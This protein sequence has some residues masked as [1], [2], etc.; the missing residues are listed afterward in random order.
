MFGGLLF[1]FGFIIYLMVAFTPLKVYLIPGYA[2]VEYRMDARMARIKAD[3][4]AKSLKQKE[5]YWA[6]VKNILTG[7][8][9][10]TNHDTTHPKANHVLITEE[11]MQLD[12]SMRNKAS[13]GDRFSLKGGVKSTMGEKNFISPVTGKIVS[14]FDLV[15]GH[16]GVD[17]GT[18]E[19]TPVKSIGDGTVVFSSYTTDG[20]HEI[21]VQ[22]AQDMIS[23][24]R[25]N[26]YLLK[27]K[28]DR[29]IGGQSIAV[30]GNIVETQIGPHLHFELWKS[31]TPVSPINYIQF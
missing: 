31:G 20:G 22:H 12:E 18:N 30:V 5:F 17:I 7:G 15:R 4:L 27:K 28:G 6:S 14:A 13:Q 23:I 11:E 8:V 24:Y 26:G 25:N 3:S 16:Y 2:D 1:G 19:S 29:V 10:S 21:H 9:N